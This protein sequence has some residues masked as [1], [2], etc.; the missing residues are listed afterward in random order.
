MS[1]LHRSALWVATLLVPFLL[2]P[3]AWAGD[4]L[5]RLDG[6]DLAI[7]GSEDDDTVIVESGGEGIFFVSGGQG[8]TV[9]GGISGE[10]FAMPGGVRV[11]LAG[12]QD[13]LALFDVSLAGPLTV[14]LGPGDD[15]VGFES[16]SVAGD[17]SV[18]KQIG[19]ASLD[20]SGLQVGSNVAFL[21][22]EGSD[23]FVLSGVDIRGDLKFDLGEGTNEVD[24]VRSTVDGR[25]RYRGGSDADVLQVADATSLH[26]RVRLKMG[27][28]SN[29][30]FAS[31]ASLGSLRYRGRGFESVII[32]RGGVV[33]GD[34]DMNARGD[35][36][37]FK[38][39]DSSIGGDLRFRAR[40]GN[41]SF[42]L[43][44]GTTVSG[45]LELATG[46]GD[47][48]VV[49]SE[50]RVAGRVRAAWAKGASR[51]PGSSSAV[52]TSRLERHRVR[53]RSRRPMWTAT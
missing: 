7:E 50:S 17:V 49:V 23:A 2:G 33:S 12:G 8:D 30:M 35:H 47:D 40:S 21:L 27:A 26:G 20:A 42:R 48:V 29:S 28:G 39:I 14:D 25:T 37:A 18:T 32:G 11:A 41:D 10:S 6:D 52:W 38:A 45:K 1:R 44:E 4:I 13:R 9:N 36:A 16:V 53:P 24:I 3:P 34:I 5:V 51:Q 31:K 22:A 15:Q 43:E 19:R 46:E